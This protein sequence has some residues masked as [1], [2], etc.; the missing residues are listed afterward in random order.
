MGGIS[1]SKRVVIGD[2][3]HVMY[4]EKSAALSPQAIRFP[5][6]NG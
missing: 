5:A 4:L 2:A 1:G 3:G 6:S